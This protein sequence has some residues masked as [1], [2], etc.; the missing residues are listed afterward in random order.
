M[1]KRMLLGLFL[2]VAALAAAQPVIT[3]L[4]GTTVSRSDRLL[5]NGSGF[6]AFQNG[7]RSK[8]QASQRCSPAGATP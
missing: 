7:G 3:G 4:S 5:I 6:G 8:S 1:K 2:L